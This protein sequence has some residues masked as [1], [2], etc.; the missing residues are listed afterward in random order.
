MPVKMWEKLESLMRLY[1]GAGK[2][3]GKVTVWPEKGEMHWEPVSRIYQAEKTL[4]II[5]KLQGKSEEYYFYPKGFSR[6]RFYLTAYPNPEMWFEEAVRL[7]NGSSPFLH[8]HP[9]FATY[10]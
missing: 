5:F 8:T 9:D 2:W 3:K 7:N 4:G 1:R 6:N 10:K